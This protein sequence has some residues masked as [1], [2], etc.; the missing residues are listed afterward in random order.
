MKRKILL[1]SL[2]VVLSFILALPAGVLAAPGEYN[3][4]DIATILLPSNL[5]PPLIHDPIGSG[6]GKE[7]KRNRKT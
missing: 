3:T 1:L 5:K 4:G 6:G 7:C 2:I